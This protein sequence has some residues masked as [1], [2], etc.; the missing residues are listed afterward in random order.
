MSTTKK[1][2]APKTAAPK[3]KK[4]PKTA[5]AAPSSTAPTKKLSALEAAV[6]VLEESQVPMSCGEMIAA[7]TSKGYW[8]S[9][10]G[11]TPAATL[12]SAILRELK[13]KGEQARFQKTERGKFAR[14]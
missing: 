8:T 7:M 11:K 12:Y 1:T 9:P 13:V 4:P 5:P 3:T 14:A 2:R 6:R 10:G